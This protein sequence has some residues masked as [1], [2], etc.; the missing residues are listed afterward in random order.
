MAAAE[1]CRSG[2]KKVRTF[3]S[4]TLLGGLHN[5]NNVTVM[6]GIKRKS[7]TASGPDIKVKS[8]KIKV[9]AP[10]GK[11]STKREKS[12]KTSKKTKKDDSDELIESDTSEDENGFYGFSADN[13][14]AISSSDDVDEQNEPE[15]KK[16]KRAD[17]GDKKEHT[18]AKKESKDDAAAEKKSSALAALNCM[19]SHTDQLSQCR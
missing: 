10:V 9:D 16:I 4:C 2:L 5:R 8:K 17:K 19:S 7:T 11:S 6:A 13:A 3:R 14:A 12:T 1:H 18:K 15:T